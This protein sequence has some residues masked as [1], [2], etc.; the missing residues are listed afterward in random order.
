MA[1]TAITLGGVTKKAGPGFAQSTDGHFAD[2][3]LWALN[4]LGSTYSDKY[5]GNLEL[6]AGLTLTGELAVSLSSSQDNYNPAVLSTISTLNITASVDIDITGITGGVAGRVIFINNLAASA[7]NIRLVNL[8][9]ST[10]ANQFSIGT[11]IT[12]KPGRGLAIRYNS[13]S[14]RW[15]LLGAGGTVS[16]VAASFTGG[17]ISVGGSPIIDAGTLALTVAGTS[18]GVPYFSS[19]STWASS[20]ALTANALMIGGGAGN[21]PAVISTGTGVLTALGTN[22]GSAGAF[23]TFNGALGSP[24]SA[25]TLPAFT[26][27]G[28]LSGGGNQVNNVIIG[29]SNALAGF[30]TTVSASTSITITASSA[31]AITIGP[32][33]STNPAF[34]VDSSVGSLVAGLL[35]TGAVTGGTVALSAIDS[36]SNTGIKI[37]AKGSGNITLGDISTGGI[38]LARL[39]TASLGIV[40]LAGGLT[41][42]AGGL[43][44]QDTI[45][46]SCRVQTNG[47]TTG[48]AFQLNSGNNTTSA[49]INYFRFQCLETTPQEWRVGN[50]GTKNFEIYNWTKSSAAP[51]LSIDQATSIAIFGSDSQI[52]NGVVATVLGA[53]GPTG[54]NTTVQEWLRVKNAAGTTRYLPM[55]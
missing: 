2:T 4:L 29:T 23:V 31:S 46:L 44:V 16:S 45:D 13:T 20:G 12:L 33:G 35:V 54:A 21:P 5:L 10:A 53:V 22:V 40:V 26:L 18:G 3:T 39:T 15:T 25:G 30:F 6:N 8:S 17:L 36:G 11:S 50:Y 7:G 27:G 14:S 24:S 42:S 37:N 48:A 28:T 32:N 9:T 51:A 38:T 47:T 19:A 55:F 1:Q 49:R 52:A 41:V 43:D 34:K